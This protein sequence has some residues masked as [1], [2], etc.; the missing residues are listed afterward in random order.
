MRGGKKSSSMT[1]PV[2]VYGPLCTSLSTTTSL[3]SATPYVN[4]SYS[5][6]DPQRLTD[7]VCSGR[8][9]ITGGGVA[10]SSSSSSSDTGGTAGVSD[11]VFTFYAE[12]TKINRSSG[13]RTPDPRSASSLEGSQ[14]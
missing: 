2:P 11:T 5:L 8:G 12:R 10:S 6:Q 1:S 9:A 3:A 7:F 13:H 14:F 4:K